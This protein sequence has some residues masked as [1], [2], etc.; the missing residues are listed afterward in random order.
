MLTMKQPNI[1]H[2]QP[3]DF[4]RHTKTKKVKMPR[5]ESRLLVEDWIIK[6]PRPNEQRPVSER[7]DL[8]V[9]A[10]QQI[11]PAPFPKES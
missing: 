7:I 6:S 8:D 9:L 2:P 4:G 11:P 1:N 10:D 3:E 5:D